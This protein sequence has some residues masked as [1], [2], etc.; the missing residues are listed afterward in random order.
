[1]PRLHF[2]QQEGTG[3]SIVDGVISQKS[4]KI[5]IETKKKKNFSISQINNHLNG[6]EDEEIRILLLIGGEILNKDKFDEIREKTVAKFNQNSQNDK[7]IEMSNISFNQVIKTFRDTIEEFDLEMQD[8]IDDYES[9]CDNENVLNK[10]DVRMRYVPCGDTF[11]LNLQYNLYYMP[12]DRGYRSHKYLGIYKNKCIRAI[13]K[14]KKITCINAD[15][16]GENIEVTE[17][18]KLND[19]EKKVLS[20]VIKEAYENYGHKVYKNHRF[21]IT[22]KLYETEFKKTSKHG[23]L[24]ARY[25]NLKEIFGKDL[26]DNVSVIADKLKKHE[27]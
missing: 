1:M 10:K 19:E 2:G 11:D 23:V 21:F 22:E 5:L 24:R 3:N 14:I 7:N 6:F 8:L 15:K 9:F 12:E 16:N 20:E 26:P 18:D 27:F 17:G 13:G 25:H 4:F